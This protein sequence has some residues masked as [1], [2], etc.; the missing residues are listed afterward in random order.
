MHKIIFGYETKIIRHL[1]ACTNLRILFP[2]S[3]WSSCNSLPC[4]L[5]IS[6][7]RLPC[8]IYS[9]C[10][11]VSSLPVCSNL[12]V[13]CLQQLSNDRHPGSFFS[14]LHS[15]NLIYVVFLLLS[16]CW[17]RVVLIDWTCGSKGKTRNLFG[18]DKLKK[19]LR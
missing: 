9:L 18:G 17:I 15:N 4:R 6:C 3:R 8:F 14:K 2:A 5:V 7:C 1:Y 11:V 19:E 10:I 12:L 13:D 16:Y